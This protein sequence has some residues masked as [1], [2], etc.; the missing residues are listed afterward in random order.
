ML[1]FQVHS[2]RYKDYFYP[3]LTTYRSSICVNNLVNVLFCLQG[4]FCKLYSKSVALSFVLHNIRVL[5]VL[6]A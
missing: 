3:M 5:S 1:P 2:A 6:K 4:L